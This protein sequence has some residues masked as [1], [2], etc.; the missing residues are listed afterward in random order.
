M[1]LF[2]DQGLPRGRCILCESRGL[3]IISSSVGF[4]VHDHMGA[5]QPYCREHG[6]ELDGVR[7]RIKAL[8]AQIEGL[9][10]TLLLFF[11]SGNLHQGHIDCP[12]DCIRCQ[13]ETTLRGQGAALVQ[14]IKHER[15][16]SEVSNEVSK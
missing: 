4:W 3:P 9:K 10:T 6:F 11:H 14:L 7:A 8:L 5:P 13:V 15:V 1:T 12:P 2:L 16:L